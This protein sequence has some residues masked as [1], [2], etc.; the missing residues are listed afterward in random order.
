MRAHFSWPHPA[1]EADIRPYLKYRRRGVGVEASA[2]GSLY[3]LQAS[4]KL[5]TCVS[6]ATWTVT[7]FQLKVSVSFCSGN[8][9]QAPKKSAIISPVPKQDL[10]FE[11]LVKTL[12]SLVGKGDVSQSELYNNVRKP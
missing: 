12:W 3:S 6:P 2:I 10:F 4:R 8:R 5:G 11:A 9:E 1:E 7:R